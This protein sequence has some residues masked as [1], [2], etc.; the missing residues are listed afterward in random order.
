MVN[1]PKKKIIKKFPFKKTDETNNEDGL[2]DWKPVK[3]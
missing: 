1:E 2:K 3:I